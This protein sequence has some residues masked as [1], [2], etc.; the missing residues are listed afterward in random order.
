MCN[1]CLLKI[2]NFINN[3]KNG[4]NPIES[5]ESDLFFL[6]KKRKSEQNFLDYQRNCM[7]QKKEIDFSLLNKT[8]PKSK[9]NAFSLVPNVFSNY[10]NSTELSFD[11][12]NKNQNSRYKLLNEF[13]NLLNKIINL[14]NNN[15]NQII[16][17]KENDL[18]SNEKFFKNEKNDNVKNIEISKFRNANN[19]LFSLMNI[20]SN[21]NDFL[22]NN[23]CKKN[24]EGNNKRSEEKAM[25]NNKLVYSNSNGTDLHHYSN[26][27]QK[28][29]KIFVVNTGRRRSKYKGSQKMEI[30]GKY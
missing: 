25:S 6:Q 14:N 27:C 3:R 18:D 26:N 29:K 4:E 11:Y 21:C 19:N 10:N 7:S 8:D 1:N 23:L 2:I 9:T 28:S 15:K 17:L 20:N 16:D 13:E 30:N 12:N 22:V 24:D 5:K